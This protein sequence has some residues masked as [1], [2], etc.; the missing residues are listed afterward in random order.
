MAVDVQ[1]GEERLLIKDARIGEMVVNPVDRS[2]IGVRH[3]DG[4]ASLVRVPYPYT[5]WIEIHKFPYEY[6]PTD[7]DI[8]RDGR[9]SYPQ[10]SARSP[11]TNSFA[12]GSST[13]Y[14]RE[15]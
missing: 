8:S 12:C 11:A 14:C 13:R 7:L 3:H 4:I 5:E 15:T 1:T 10:P 6:V 2:L 9:H